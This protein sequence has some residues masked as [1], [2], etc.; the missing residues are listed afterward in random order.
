M[1][2]ASRGGAAS[3]TQW[4]AASTPVEGQGAA[5]S[6]WRAT[7]SA[8]NKKKLLE[9]MHRGAPRQEHESSLNR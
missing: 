6:P 9:G 7:E 8:R 4:A 2:E 5:S 1:L 3:R